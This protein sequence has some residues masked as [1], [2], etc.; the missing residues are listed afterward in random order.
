MSQSPDAGSS[1]AVAQPKVARGPNLPLTLG[2]GC[3]G[4]LVMGCLL[5]AGIFVAAS[6][7][8]RSSDAYQLALATAQREPAVTAEL[9][10]PVRAGWLATGQIKVAGSSGEATLEIPLSGPRGSATLDVRANKLAGSWSFSTLNV[11]IP[12]RPAPLNLLATA[13]P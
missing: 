3:F 2:L 5:I 10:A 8:L 11:R 9:G 13:T 6:V 12:G 4:L 1:L 7:A